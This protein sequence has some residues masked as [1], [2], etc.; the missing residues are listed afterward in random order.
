MVALGLA[1]A[2]ALDVDDAAHARVDRRDVDRAAGLEQH[3]VAGVAE[4]GEQRQRAGLQ[5][6][7]A[8]GELD[9]RAAEGGDPCEH[10]GARQPLPFVEGVGRCRTSDSA[11]GSR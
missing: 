1:R 8:A 10:F 3:L 6:R 9:E 11:G 5:Q 4:V 2:R 7:L